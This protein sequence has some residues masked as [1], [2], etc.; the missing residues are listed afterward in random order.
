M[1]FYWSENYRRYF[2]FI[3]FYFCP[4]FVIFYF[5]KLFNGLGFLTKKVLPIEN[6]SSLG[7]S[8]R[9][10]ADITEPNVLIH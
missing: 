4:Y 5:V 7:M 1:V 9:V 10:F 8:L 6:T 3:Y 2:R